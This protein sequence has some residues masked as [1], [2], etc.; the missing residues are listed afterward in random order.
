MCHNTEVFSQYFM[1]LLFLSCFLGCLRDFSPEAIKFISDCF[2][3]LYSWRLTTLLKMME[4][5]IRWLLNYFEENIMKYLGCFCMMHK[6]IPPYLCLS[7]H[8]NSNSYK[9]LNKEINKHKP[10]LWLHCSSIWSQVEIW[11]NFLK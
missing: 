6:W 11:K 10:Y 1:N 3:W 7:Y 4:I 5:L 2:I 8:F 9:K